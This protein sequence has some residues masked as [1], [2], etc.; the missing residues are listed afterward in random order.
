MRTSLVVGCLISVV[1]LTIVAQQPPCFADP[2]PTCH[3]AG[4]IPCPVCG[5][6][7]YIPVNVHGQP[8]AYGCEACGGVRGDPFGRGGGRPGSGRVPC[9][10]CGG[11]GQAP[12]PPVDEHA[13]AKALYQ[14]GL[15]CFNQRDWAEAIRGFEAALGKWPQY[16]DAREK[17]AQ[18]LYQDGLG[19]SR[20]GEWGDAIKRFETALARCVVGDQIVAA[21]RSKLGEAW[22]GQRLEDDRRQRAAFQDGI[23]DL[24]ESINADSSPSALPRL[25]DDGPGGQGGSRTPDI[26]R[27]D[28]PAANPQ[29]ARIARGL[30]SIQVPPPLTADEASVY[31]RCPSAE[32]QEK[33]L[34]GPEAGVAAV[35]FELLRLTGKTFTVLPRVLFVTGKTFIAME[36]GAD[37][38]LVKQDR[39]YESALR[40]L[41]D[42]R[43]APL[44]SA[45]VN[46][47]YH[48]RPPPADAPPDMIPIARAILDHRLGNTG[49]RIAWS[50]M[51]SPEAKS[52]ALSR[53][54][55]E[56]GG[57]LLGEGVEGTV[58]GLMAARDPAFKGG[59]EALESAEAAL[60]RTKDPAERAALEKVIAH[61]DTILVRT[62]RA[63]ANAMGNVDSLTSYLDSIRPH[64]KEE[65]DHV[66]TRMD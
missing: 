48:G 58:E 4:T 59:L 28:T 1:C 55:I 8:G 6:L 9:P 62:Y 54:C 49:M 23:R 36:D 24:I 57:E 22:E 16:E 30:D 64:A 17:L 63:G 44:F 65:G 34:L 10:T 11:T 66:P 41:K 46:A 31:F 21:I 13:D 45:T 2:C 12:G 38:Y 18:A 43:R 39:L 27:D 5:G 40:L 32:E 26:Y 51:W 19:L 20:R 42:K 25:P 53:A 7:G 33:I 56:L 15:N 60:R 35:E 37:I 29:I 52:A 61:A 3:G 47:L 14:E 50:A